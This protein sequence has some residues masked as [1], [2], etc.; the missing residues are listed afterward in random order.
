VYSLQKNCNTKCPS[1][2][3]IVKHDRYQVSPLAT[4]AVAAVVIVVV[5]IV[6]AT[7]DLRQI[8]LHRRD[9]TLARL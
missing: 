8:T 7:D 2:D 6:V 9:F 5:V 1:Y 4:I 3:D